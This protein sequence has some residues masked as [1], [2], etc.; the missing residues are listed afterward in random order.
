MSFHFIIMN[1]DVN[2]LAKCVASTI[3]GYDCENVNKFDINTAQTSGLHL[4]WHRL[5]EKVN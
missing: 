2:A 1:K 5:T 4:H 3:N